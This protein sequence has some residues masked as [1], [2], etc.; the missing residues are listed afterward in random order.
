MFNS[1]VSVPLSGSEKSMV[2][3]SSLVDIT[4]TGQCVAEKSWDS[5]GEETEGLRGFPLRGRVPRK[6]EVW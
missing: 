6:L 2:A 3:V 1:L 4:S 5:L